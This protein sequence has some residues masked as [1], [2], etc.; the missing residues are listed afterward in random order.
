MLEVAGRTAPNWLLSPSVV[1][2]RRRH[3]TVSA[4]PG[5]VSCN[6]SNTECLQATGTLAD[7][8]EAC[9][10]SPVSKRN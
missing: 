3:A 5:Y 2:L 8:L 6:N 1:S 4:V 10:T 9:V 7:T